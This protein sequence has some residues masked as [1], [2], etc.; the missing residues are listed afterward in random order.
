LIEKN[1]K[2]I[3][4]S[5]IKD[6]EREL[7][8][9]SDEEFSRDERVLEI[10]LSRRIYKIET[11]A[12]R[13][14]I[15]RSGRED[16]LI[17]PRRLCTCPDFIINVVSRGRRSSCIHLRAVEYIERRGLSVPII[18]DVDWKNV[19]YKVVSIGSL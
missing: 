11:R 5:D 19:M 17:I 4:K 13:A 14:Y 10:I 2:N 8:E 18:K 7:S 16:Y 9:T 6:L 3:E 15:Y 1:L 12:G